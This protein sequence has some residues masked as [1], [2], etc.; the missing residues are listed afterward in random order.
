MCLL[1]AAGNKVPK[2]TSLDAWK[3]NTQQRGLAKH[4]VST[5]REDESKSIGASISNMELAPFHHNPADTN[6]KGRQRFT[7]QSG[8]SSSSLCNLIE[9]GSSKWLPHSCL[10][11]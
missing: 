1:E 3:Q 11:L 6:V 9:K 5:E 8:P 4:F 10:R 2:D 7:I